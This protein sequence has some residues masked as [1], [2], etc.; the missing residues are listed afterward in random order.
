MQSNGRWNGV[1]CNQMGDG[2][3]FAIKWGKEM[4]WNEV[5]CFS[6]A[7]PPPDSLQS[8]SFFFNWES[9]QWFLVTKIWIICSQHDEWEV[10]VVVIAPLLDR[11][12]SES[13]ER[14]YL[15]NDST[16]FLFNR[17]SGKFCC[18]QREFEASEAKQMEHSENMSG[19]HQ[20]LASNEEHGL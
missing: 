9:V 5:G 12:L 17:R 20:V 7:S 16:A 8:T 15:E 19:T 13:N 1:C 3:V 10:E 11:P 4:R 2:M 14:R 6:T 18:S